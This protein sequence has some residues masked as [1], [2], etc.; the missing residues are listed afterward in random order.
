MQRLR[1]AWGGGGGG[2]GGGGCSKN[3]SRNFSSLLEKIN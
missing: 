1:E 2:G 3:T